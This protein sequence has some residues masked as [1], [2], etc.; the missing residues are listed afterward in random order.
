MSGS[1][2][3]CE[4]GEGP[5]WDDSRQELT[6]VDLTAGRLHVASVD[7]PCL[8]E[9]VRT[10]GTGSRT[11]GI[12]V[13]LPSSGWLVATGPSL[14]RLSMMGSLQHLATL[15]RPGHRLNDGA[16]DPRGRFWVGG[17]ADDAR[18]GSGSLF[19]VDLD[20][21]VSRVLVDM[22][23]PNGL[24]WSPDGGTMYVTDSGVR[25]ITAYDYDVGSGWLGG[26][27][28]FVRLDDG[29][30]PDGLCVDSGGGVWVATST[31]RQVRRFAPDGTVTMILDVPAPRVSAC[32]FVGP[33]RDVLAVT[34]GSSGG[35][36]EGRLFLYPTRA[37][38]L[39]SPPFSGELPRGGEDLVARLF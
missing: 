16:C 19:R 11:L 33:E 23:H 28:P 31:G 4:S 9:P 21:S 17:M 7:G 34:T 10:C 1:G 39:P 36:P 12:A 8:Q 18:P 37:R 5:R 13:P 32:A 35:L 24:G 26:P 38:G 20:G 25:E 2:P 29:G 3:L 15:E 27:R 30:V 14:A 6:W 22:T